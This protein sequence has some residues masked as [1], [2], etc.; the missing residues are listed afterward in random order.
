MK[1]GSKRSELVQL[2]QKFVPRNLVGIFHNKR[3]RSTP[4]DPKLMFWCISYS[5]NAFV[6]ILFTYETRFKT[7]ELVQL[8]RKFVLR[9]CV[10][11]FC[12]EHTRSTPLDPKL[13][14]WRISYSLGTFGTV[15]FSYETRLKMGRIGVINAKVHAT[16]SC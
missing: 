12:N 2:M 1:L 13:L 9:R 6:T 4:L 15:L 8:M 5:L 11:I 3:T 16:K 14:F 7:G 10:R